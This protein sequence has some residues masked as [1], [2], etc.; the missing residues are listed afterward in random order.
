MDAPS[1]SQEPVTDLLVQWSD[2]DGAALAEFMSLVSVPIRSP[3][4]KK[5]SM[6][7]T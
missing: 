5:F 1:V 4:D 2:G 7:A 6:S 3:L